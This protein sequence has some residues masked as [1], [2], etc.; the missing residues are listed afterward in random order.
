M[1]GE[2][3][4]LDTLISIEEIRQLMARYARLADEKRWADLARLFTP[5]G[6]FTSYAQDG[7]IVAD[8]HGR[9]AIE[10]NLSAVN[11]G[12]VQP[13]HMFLTSEIEPTGPD[14]A[15]G[16]YAMADLIYR[17]EGYDGKGANLPDFRVM[18]GWGHYDAEFVK[19]G[20][21]WYIRTLVQTR[22][23]LEF[24]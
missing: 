21:D 13:I 19:D 22:T 16:N 3:M 10:E 12:D 18:R 6:T 5:D 20:G 17:G 11:A 1:K 7:S 2:L 14:T 9:Q 23:R 8:M 24:E 15:K 4:N